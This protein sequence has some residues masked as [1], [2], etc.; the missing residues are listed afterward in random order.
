MWPETPFL[1]IVLWIL[2]LISSLIFS[3]IFSWDTS[4]SRVASETESTEM[5]SGNCILKIDGI[6]AFCRIKFHGN[7]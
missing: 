4:L 7:Y 5:R 6:S 3:W 2:M 1:R